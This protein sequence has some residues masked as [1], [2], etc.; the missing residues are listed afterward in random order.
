M[1]NETIDAR[2][3]AAVAAERRRCIDQVLT[4]AVLREEAAVNLDKAA[5]I[6]GDEKPSEGASERVRMQAEVARDIASF[7]AGR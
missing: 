1:S 4:Y 2:I 6:D 7:L 3:E 5:E